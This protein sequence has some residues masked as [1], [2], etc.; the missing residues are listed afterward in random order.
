MVAR[1]D[2]S[3]AVAAGGAA[4]AVDTMADGE[5]GAI[6]V[7]AGGAAC[8]S[9]TMAASEEG[10][11]TVVAAA[12]KGAVCAA[13]V[14]AAEPVVP[15]R[16]GSVLQLLL[17]SM[18]MRRDSWVHSAHHGRMSPAPKGVS[19]RLRH[20]SARN[21]QHG[22]AATTGALVLE[23]VAVLLV[24]ILQASCC[25]DTAMIDAAPMH[26]AFSTAPSGTSGIIRSIP[27]RSNTAV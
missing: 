21:L 10:A 19:K 17:S 13:D 3:V 26:I 7:V 5:E 27:S 11:V 6:M 8:A 18:L 12:V 23:T 14:E 1:Q 15:P 9:D 20:C 24:E 25:S 22:S 16:A 4:R 2:G